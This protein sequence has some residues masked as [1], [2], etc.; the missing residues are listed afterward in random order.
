LTTLK[1]KPA[2]AQAHARQY[3]GGIA[4][5]ARALLNFPRESLDAQHSRPPAEFEL[6]R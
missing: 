4:D 2:T 1:H 6:T 5:A 3:A